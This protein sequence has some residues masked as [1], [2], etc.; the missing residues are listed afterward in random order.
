MCV[1]EPK[2]KARVVFCLGGPG[3][4]KGTQCA[5]LSDFGYVHLSAGEL[6]RRE[7][8]SGS[9]DG[10]LIESYLSEGDIVPVALSLGLLKK[11]MERSESNYFVVDGFPRNIDNVQG[12]RDA[13]RDVADVDCVLFFDV[14]PEV[15]MERML[16]RGQT[17]GRSDDTLATAH[18]R[19][20]TYSEATLPLIEKFEH[21]GDFKVLR[22][23][24]IGSIDD[25]W[26][27]THDALR[28]FFPTTEDKK[29]APH[30]KGDDR[31]HLNG[32]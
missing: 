20:A 17:S 32:D 10:E 28:P 14:P 29:Q 4:G 27:R 19:L 8:A 23:K 11:E 6:L 30:T 2:K 21:D 12:W 7:R 9:K 5:R 1:K 25:V 18:K 31:E 3:A 15:L 26:Q 22:V 16:E 24:G 13:M